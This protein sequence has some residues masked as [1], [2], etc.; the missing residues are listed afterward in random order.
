LAAKLTS[1]KIELHSQSEFD[2][3]SA[4]A[5][6]DAPLR[7]LDPASEQAIAALATAGIT[8]ASQVERLGLEDL[9]KVNGVTE[10]MAERIY[11]M[12][13]AALATARS[14]AAQAATRKSAAAEDAEEDIEEARD[15]EPEASSETTTEEPDFESPAPDMSGAG[16]VDEQHG[17]SGGMS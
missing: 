17:A 2:A 12:A 4:A 5:A 13:L 7:N 9:A 1:W 11:G 10:A 14:A 15:E 3:R 16:A 6:A 8:T